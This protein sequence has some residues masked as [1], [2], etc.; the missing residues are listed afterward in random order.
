MTNLR[1]FL[2]D[3]REHKAILGYPWFTVF[4]PCIN[5]KWGWI[6]TT[7]LPV[8]FSTPNAQKA[9]YTHRMDRHWP[10]YR[11]QYFIGRVT[12]TT[13]TMMPSPK[14]PKEYQSHH[15]V[16]SEEQ[17]QQLPN[18][19]IWDHAIELLHR[20]P[21]S[22]PG[23]LL[24][25]NLEEKAEI[26][27]FVQEHLTWGTIHISKSPYAVNFFFVKKKD[28]KLWLVQDYRPLNKW[29]KKNKNISPLINQIINHLSG[30]TMFTMVD[31]CWGYNNIWIKEGDKW[32]AAFLTLEGLFEPT[33]MLF[34][35]TNTLATFQTMMNAIFWQE[36]REG[37]LSVY[38]DDMAIHT[39]KLPHESE[40]QH[41]QR[42]WSYIH[43]VLTKL[44]ENDLYL[45]PEKCEF[46]KEEIEYLGVI[47]GKNHLW[48]SPKKLQGV[49]NW[50]T[51]KTPTNVW[52]FLG[53]TGYYHYFIPNCSTITRPLLD[54]TKKTTPWHWG[55]H[56]FKAFEELKMRMCSSP[57]LTQLDFNKQFILCFSLWCGCHTLPGG[58]PPNP[59]SCSMYKT[60]TAPNS[61]LLCHIYSYRMKLWHLWTR[62][63]HHHEGT[64]PLATVLR[65]DKG[66]IHHTNR[67]HQFTILEVT[68]KP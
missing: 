48:M 9:K 24:P 40:E 17:S 60:C 2:S 63:P 30:C 36:V 3:L 29:T 16:S 31:I 47:V 38:M 49:A 27:K 53:F 15:K 35:L 11:D 22:L 32:K 61:L 44:E 62:A 68:K 57:V 67:P 10:A 55:E 6:N 33:V 51:P 5:W 42:H 52:W 64:G 13:P 23:W 21:D 45:K 28:G 25:L 46:K 19:S 8:I 20:A 66:P 26:H 50:P 59:H 4:Q 14:I 34:G 39:T 43:R 7:Q 12:F 41:L 37:W 56:Q 54:L 65:M 1:F 58:W 18:H